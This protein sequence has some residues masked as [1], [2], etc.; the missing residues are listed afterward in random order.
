M[1]LLDAW[2]RELRALIPAGF[3]RRDR[4]GALF[5]SDFPR[6]AADG[7][8]LFQSLADAGYTA[9]TGADGLA[10]I[11][12]TRRK[13]RAFLDALPA[14]RPAPTESTLALYALA[15]CLERH[16]APLEDQRTA[17]LYEIIK[18]LDQEDQ[19]ALESRLRPLIALR[20]REKA[21][22]PAAGGRMI[23]AYLSGKEG[24]D[25]SC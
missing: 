2:R 14:S 10:R 15:D 24:A 12:V 8:F 21:P 17:D 23:F 18:L 6:R 22:L 7:A 9:E 4:G 20:Q 25:E 3:L 11:G 13:L 16:P 1:R 5:V 19:T